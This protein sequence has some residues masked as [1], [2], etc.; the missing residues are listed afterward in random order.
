MTAASPDR[1]LLET[2]IRIVDDDAEV[3]E[4]LSF[5][6]SCKG[7]RT[8]AWGSAD[9]FLRDYASSPAGCL[10]LDIR[11]PGMSG[12]ELQTRMKELSFTLP[13]IFVT[14]HGD[15]RTAVRTLKSGAFDFLE[16]PVDPQA[17]DGAIRAACEISLAQAGGRLEPDAIRAIVAEMSP[18]EREISALLAHGFENG[19]IA[20]RLCLAPPARCRGTATTS[21]T[22]CA[23]TTS[24]S[25]WRSCRASTSAPDP[26]DFP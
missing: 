21:T 19:D 25:S 26:S 16:K 9:A 1:I 15:V 24:G 10:L 17:L 23:C 7:W 18:R 13:I 2:L 22:S 12:L 11:M 8:A 6:L 4:A 14:G 3:R 20:E 5:M